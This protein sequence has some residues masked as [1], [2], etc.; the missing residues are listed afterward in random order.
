MKEY[1]PQRIIDYVIVHELIHL[2]EPTHSD[3]FWSKLQAILPDY[4][5][6]KEWLRIHG[7]TLKP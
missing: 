3:T 7:N 1:A 6:R 5:D 4:Q 2:R